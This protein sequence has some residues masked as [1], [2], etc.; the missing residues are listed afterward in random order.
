MASNDGAYS[1]PGALAEWWDA[2]A[3][4]TVARLVPSRAARSNHG[5]NASPSIGDAAADCDSFH[6]V[7]PGDGAL[8]SLADEQV[9]ATHRRGRRSRI[10][11][12]CSASSNRDNGVSWRCEASTPAE[13]SDCCFAPQDRHRWSRLGRAVLLQV[14]HTA[15]TVHM[16]LEIHLNLRLPGPGGDTVL[17][18][19]WVGSDA[20]HLQVPGT[21]PPGAVAAALCGER[22]APLPPP[23]RASLSAS[24]P[25]PT[26]N[27][28]M[29]DKLTV[30]AYALRGGVAGEAGRGPLP[31]AAAAPT[32]LRRASRIPV[33]PG[34][35]ASPSS[36]AASVLALVDRRHEGT[37]NPL[38]SV[39]DA[40]NE[41]RGAETQPCG[42]WQSSLACANVE[43]GASGALSAA[44]GAAC[45]VV[46]VA[47]PALDVQAPMA[48][49][50]CDGMRA[51]V[52]RVSEV[53]VGVQPASVMPAAANRL[54]SRALTRARD[55][56]WLSC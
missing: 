43:G 3:V 51:R 9:F 45:C 19:R 7:A 41:R 47:P 23:L 11:L 53:A 44:H 48:A 49:H 55:G 37:S 17:A 31:G 24:P 56:L 16:V 30:R 34:A 6:A 12:S 40:H 1:G 52:A 25:L 28:A 33:S 35:V 50:S 38:K 2:G 14:P 10:A 21:D 54:H 15:P 46:L 4:C 32:T 8:S 5:V 29:P 36:S 42:C 39:L 18:R 22:Y 20:D 13:G 26:A 27:V